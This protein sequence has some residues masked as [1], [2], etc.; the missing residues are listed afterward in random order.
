MTAIALPV[1]LLASSLLA[2]PQDPKIPPM[3]REVY[4]LRGI[5]GPVVR[6]LPPP[7]TSFVR[8]RHWQGELSDEVGGVEEDVIVAL[9]R[10]VFGADLE[11]D[12]LQLSMLE[13]TLV[14]EGDPGTVAEVGRALEQLARV[15]ARPITVQA[16]LYERGDGAAPDPFLSP[17]QVQELQGGAPLWRAT[18]VVR[19]GG[20]V[21]LGNEQWTRYVAD[22]DV[23]V[24]QKSTIADPKIDSFFEGVRLLIEPHALAG[25]EELAVF[26]WCALGWRRA[27]PERRSAVAGSQPVLD[28][29]NVNLNT[30]RMS[31]RIADRGGLA[32]TVDGAAEGGSRLVL[33]VSAHHSEPPA[34]AP[35]PLHLIPISALTTKSFRTAPRLPRGYPELPGHEG[36]QREGQ[37]APYGLV[38]SDTLL[39]LVGDAAAGQMTGDEVSQSGSFLVVEGPGS[40]RARVERAVQ[41]LQDRWL[42]NAEI[43]ART[44]LMPVGAGPAPFGRGSGAET[45]GEGRDLHAVALPALLDR[46]HIVNRGSETT[47]IRDYDVEI[48]AKAAASNPIVQEVFTGVSVA[49]RP[50]SS[51]RGMGA[52]VLVDLSTGGKLDRRPAETDQIGDLYLSSDGRA[53][54]RQNDG[55]RPGQDV[56]LGWGPVVEIEGRSWRT[57]QEVRIT[58]R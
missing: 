35:A 33:V 39:R 45:A 55:W 41:R 50:Y 29:P 25:T 21:A 48:A 17:G 10:R 12:R 7:M 51:I 46:E 37:L 57:S 32:L 56:S 24:A 27:P 20:R 14:A 54:F 43:R 28:A 13:E 4:P 8:I 30:A 11:A 9:M 3:A 23:E 53:R 40:A 19:A 18:A 16:A 52:D 58:P 36:Y 34:E 47:V 31:G 6:P 38:D 22:V 44:R 15:V 5:L 2:P 1:L 42:R 26:C 49:V